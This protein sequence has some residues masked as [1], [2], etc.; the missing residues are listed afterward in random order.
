MPPPHPLVHQII[1]KLLTAIVFY[2]FVLQV[3]CTSLFYIQRLCAAM[4]LTFDVT[5]TKSLP[6]LSLSYP[7]ELTVRIGQTVTTNATLSGHASTWFYESGFYTKGDVN[8]Y[9]RAPCTLIQNRIF[10]KQYF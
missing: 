6:R 2:R 7:V 1:A 10:L 5:V 8:C 3:L 4:R 9:Q